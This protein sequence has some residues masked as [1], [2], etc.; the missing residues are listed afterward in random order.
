MNRDEV[1]KLAMQAWLLD[2]VDCSSDYFIRGDAGIE[3]LGKFAALVAEH[4]RE[5]VINLL[6]GI[7]KDECEDCKPSFDASEIGDGFY[8][9]KKLP[10]RTMAKD[11]AMKL[12][13]EALIAAKTNHGVMFMSDPPQEAWKFN[14]VDLKIFRAE[15]AL[16]QAL[17]QP[18]F[19]YGQDPNVLP[20]PDK[21]AGRE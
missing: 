7:D 2:K 9:S 3:E 21:G 11:E 14:Q 17:E 18:Q 1:I 5:A 19:F 4:E 16:R 15:E 20:A 6:K 13:L 12:A 10:E 8:Y